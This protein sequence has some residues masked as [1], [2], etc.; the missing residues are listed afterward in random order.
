MEN[1]K[2]E[3]SH[4]RIFEWACHFEMEKAEAG[5]QYISIDP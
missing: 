3:I 1:A 5:N 4:F 2:R